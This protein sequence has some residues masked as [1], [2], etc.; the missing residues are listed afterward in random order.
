MSLCNETNLE[1][2]LQNKTCQNNRKDYFYLTSMKIYKYKSKI[3]LLFHAHKLNFTIH[4]SSCFFSLNKDFPS[5]ER[6][7][8]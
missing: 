5:F 6:F 1:I 3:K 2:I 8:L 4:F 7:K